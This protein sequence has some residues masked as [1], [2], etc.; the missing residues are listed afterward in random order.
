MI[1]TDLNA[2]SPVDGRYLKKTRLLSPYFSEYA[3]I[4]YRLKVEVRWLESLAANELIPEVPQMSA[5]SHDFLANILSQFD[6][7]EA[8]KV[9]AYEKKPI[10]T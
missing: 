6:E 10:M 1:L 9:K 3:L 8:A 2:I 7:T 5:A 4:H